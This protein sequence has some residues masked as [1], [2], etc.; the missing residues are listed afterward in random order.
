KLIGV[1]CFGQVGRQRNW[2]REDVL[3][4]SH[5]ANLLQQVLSNTQHMEIQ[6][7]LARSNEELE[8]RVSNRTNELEKAKNALEKSLA[9]VEQQK[10]SVEQAQRN[11]AVLSEIG[12]EITASLD[13]EAIMEGLYRHVHELMDA[14]IFAIGIYRED[15][16]IIEFPYYLE[17]GRRGIPYT[18]TMS[19]PNQLAVW[20][21]THQ[22][23]VVVNDIDQ[24]LKKYIDAQG[25]AKLVVG[26]FGDDTTRTQPQSLIYAPMV[27]KGRVLGTISVHSVKKH[28]YQ[29]FHIDI[30]QTL[31]AYAAVALDNADTYRQLK[32][33]QQQLVSSEQETREA[34]ALL[35]AKQGVER[36]FAE[37]STYLRA[38]GQHAM[39]LVTDP[40][41][42][43]IQANEKYL[44]VSGFS[45]E[46]LL[47]QRHAVVNSGVHVKSFFAELWATI[48]RGDTWRGEICNRAKSG[49]M[50]W[51]DSAIVPLKDDQ[52]TISRYIAISIDITER[53]RAEQQ[54]V[55]MA[56]HDALT[57]LPNRN[58]LQD[59]IQQ[60]LAHNRRSQESAAVLFIDLDQFKTI[61]DSLG[62]DVGDLLLIEVAGRLKSAVRDED[63]VA[64]QGGDEFIVLLPNIARAHDAGMLGE[65][66]LEV[67]TQPYRVNGNELHVSASIGIA[68]SPDD[69]QD[70]DTLLKCSDIAM[71]HAKE[72]GR[73]NCQF[74]TPKMNDTAAERHQ[75]G[76]ELRHALARNELRLHYQ[77]ILSAVDGNLIGMEVLLRWQHPLRGLIS[78]TRFVPLAEETGLIVPIGEW[79]LETACRQA[80]A[81]RKQGFHVPRMSINLSARQFHSKHLF[82]TI[83][84]V[85][86]ETGIEASLIELEITEGILIQN[87]DDVIET[88][89]RLKEMG[90]H[91]SI[92]D[93]G[94][95]Y[96]SLSYL[97]RFPIDTLKIDRS[98][99]TDVP[100]D[101]DDAA[102]VTAIIALAHSLRMD[103]IAEGVE[104]AEQLAFLRQQGC[105][106]YQGFFF[107]RPVAA[108]E[109]EAL[110]SP[111][112]QKPAKSAKSV[113]G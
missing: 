68:I 80:K 67:L 47:G 9:E 85:L 63:T 22:R 39:V 77:P 38:I 33:A 76:L 104:Q 66:L 29:P 93:F 37:L 8:Q 72:N 97:K 106:H 92:D 17:S 15:Q 79:V 19:D 6:T 83:V 43:I 98:F 20:C 105:D 28:G 103:V 109:M 58:L 44:E 26:R 110:L 88:L 65:K 25:L 53:K 56:T 55:H 35:V 27:I 42:R 21:V 18:R 61:N 113:R 5:I 59:R 69:G 89:F 57:G 96:S 84:R 2:T 101:A 87:T 48:S 62:H 45:Q 107:S 112:E 81:W 34:N 78:P 13:G 32:Q 86:D 14:D 50:F 73:N 46:E 52:G 70:V 100:K 82:A 71:Y 12:M 74:F 31:A 60:A 30:L 64:R 95:G 7:Q 75:M 108:F 16:Q 36:A 94:T 10:R 11:I 49:E 102:I 4:G 90:L 40:S 41:G 3:F 99:I 91:V 24:D 111:V 1:V 51:E 54:M 23:E